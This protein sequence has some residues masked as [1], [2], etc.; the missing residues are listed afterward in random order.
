MY[1]GR[2][3]GMNCPYCDGHLPEREEV[4]CRHWRCYECRVLWEDMGRVIWTWTKDDGVTGF[5]VV[6]QGTLLVIGTRSRCE[7]EGLH[8]LRL[9]I[10]AH[11]H[12]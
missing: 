12:R 6:P 1:F 7:E 9:S 3:T 4:E 8:E 2:R 11:A 5:D 10:S